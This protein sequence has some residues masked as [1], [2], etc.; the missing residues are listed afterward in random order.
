MS[1]FIT[2]AELEGMQ[3]EELRALYGRLLSDLRRNPQSRFLTSDVHVSLRHVEQAL[4]RFA[5]RPR[6]PQGPRF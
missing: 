6:T 4:A 5:Q 1:L 3:I 2:P